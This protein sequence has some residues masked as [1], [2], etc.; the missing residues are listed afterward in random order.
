MTEVA[1]KVRNRQQELRCFVEIMCFLKRGFRKW[2]CSRKSLHT[3]ATRKQQQQK[4]GQWLIRAALLL[5]A[6]APEEYTK[7]PPTD[8]DSLPFLPE[9]QTTTQRGF[10]RWHT[11]I[12]QCSNRATRRQ[13]ARMPIKIGRITRHKDTNIFFISRGTQRT[14]IS[15]TVL[16]RNEKRVHKPHTTTYPSKSQRPVTQF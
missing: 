10:T 9:H 4:R 3:K 16:C 6:A 7:S 2:Q 1:G 15:C 5:S 8:P 11:T 13:S 14:K 12:K